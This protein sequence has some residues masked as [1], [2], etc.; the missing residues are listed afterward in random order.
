MQ[1]YI[2]VDTSGSMEGAKIGA[3]NDC[4]SNLIISLQE[5]AFNGCDLS[6]S[7]LSFARQCR[8]MQEKPLAILDFDW[9]ELRANGMTSL[10]AACI[11]LN[12]WLSKYGSVEEPANIILLSDGCPTDDFDEGMSVLNNN[13]VFTNAHK[14]SIAI[15][16]DASVPTLLQF[17]A[18]ENSIYKVDT[19]SSLIDRLTSIITAITTKQSFVRAVKSTDDED[20]WS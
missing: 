9:G 19:V 17:T 10:G 16:D 7:V 11:E 12:S 15:G 4:M 2:L 6:V 13:T 20:E 3:I 8:W 18:D 5:V 14:Y 1:L